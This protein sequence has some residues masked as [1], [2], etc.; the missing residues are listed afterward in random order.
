MNYDTELFIILIER[1]VD[2]PLSFIPFFLHFL[3][4]GYLILFNKVV[5]P[6]WRHIDVIFTYNELSVKG[7][8]LPIL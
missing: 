8:Y 4:L 1:I 5:Q 6:S 3:L 2:W 7:L